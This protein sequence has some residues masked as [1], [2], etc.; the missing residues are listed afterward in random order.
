M[1]TVRVWFNHWFSTA[2]HLIR[3]LKEDEKTR[4]AV[5]GSNADKNCV[6][7]AVCDE[8]AT[9]P[10]IADGDEYVD[11]CLA[12][13]VER[14]IDVFAPRRHMLS[15][16]RRLGEFDAIGVKTLVERDHRTMCVLSDKAKTYSML[17]AAGFGCVPAHSVV[18]DVS[19][20]VAAYGRHKTDK[21]RVCM[22]Y[23]VDEGAASFRVVDGN[24][25]HNLASKV[26]AKITYENSVS[27]LSR[28]G[29][30]PA[31]LVM[32]YI[33][34]EEISVDCLPMPGG[35]H[36]AIPR[37]K[38]FGR[39][40]TIRFDK[41]IID[42]CD[43]FLCAAKLECPCNLQ[44]KYDSGIPYL[45]EVNTRMSGGMHLSC[46]ATGANIPNI[47]VN[48]LLGVQKPASCKRI[49]Q[50]VS[51]I[52]TPVIMAQAANGQAAAGQAATEHVATGQAAKGQAAAEQAANGQAAT[53]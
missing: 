22:K 7:R 23:A 10:K 39:S 45:L 14:K 9:E 37:F 36:I 29:E 8:W 33:P 28:L 19:G 40:E 2:Y 13:C 30:F 41:S 11:F 46:M 3:L 34:G 38:S 4:F 6:Y 32:P 49:K 44:F 21:N 52:E 50:I 43:S 53:A 25:G 47:A 42:I 18:T 1:R 12:F 20:Y 51:Y 31:L 27:A 26:G 24:V 48:R 16:S 15:I 35:D 5:V 17:A